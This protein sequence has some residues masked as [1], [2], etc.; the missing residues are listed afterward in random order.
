MDLHCSQLQGFF[1]IPLDHL[2][3][4]P[5]LAKHFKKK[6]GDLSD[7]MAV[8]PDLGSVGRARSF[9]EKLNIP[10][11]IVDKRRPREN[12]SEI[13]N[14]VGDVNGK[15]IILVDDMIDTAG[16]IVT[17]ANSVKDFGD[18]DV[19]GCCTHAIL[20]GPAAKRINESAI[21]E[22]VALNTMEM[23][24]DKQINKLTFI[25]VESIFADSISRIHE[26][27]PVSVLSE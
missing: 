17:A 6:F 13:M 3:G 18:K 5:V 1:D 7:F 22:L 20:S 27:L 23:P 9:A 25:S 14:I 15:N 26:G 16:S 2:V 10:I 21:K 4:V 8:S 12:E 24:K 11:A 19:Y